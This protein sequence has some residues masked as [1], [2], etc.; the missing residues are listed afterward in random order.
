[1]PPIP[2]PIF[3][4]LIILLGIVCDTKAARP[5]WIAGGVAVALFYLLA[6]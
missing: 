1:M 4:P 6:L 2:G 3:W 5:W